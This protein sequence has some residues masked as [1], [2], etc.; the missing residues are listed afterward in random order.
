[1][2]CGTQ[3]RLPTCTAP[4]LAPS[5]MDCKLYC[6]RCWVMSASTQDLLDAESVTGSL[7]QFNP[8]RRLRKSAV[9]SAISRSRQRSRSRSCRHL[10]S[11]QFLAV[12]P[13]GGN[14]D[15]G[16]MWARKNRSENRFRFPDRG[17]TKSRGQRP[18][19][20]L[21]T[22]RPRRDALG[23]QGELLRLVVHVGAHGERG[24]GVP[25]PGR[26]D[27]HRHVVLQVHERAAGVPG[28]V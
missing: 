2:V 18:Y 7:Q 17:R 16:P 14:R 1:M 26:D 19:C 4:M 27:R 12:T 22:P 20:G 13:G 23:R 28:V 8:D 3:M 11:T 5:K 25:E 21:V 10:P 24:V 6:S 15:V 9:Q